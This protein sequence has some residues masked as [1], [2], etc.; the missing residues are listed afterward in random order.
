MVNADY[1]RLIQVLT[2]LLSNAAKFSPPN[3]EVEISVLRHEKNIRISVT[4]HGPGIPKEFHDRIFERFAQ[5]DPM[6]PRH[7]QGAGLGLSIVKAIVERLGGMIDFE[8]NPD[9]GTTFY[10]ELPEY[11]KDEMPSAPGA[12]TKKKPTI[13]ICEDDPDVATLLSLILKQGGY[14]TEIAYDATQAKQLL[15][16]NNYSAMTLDIKLPDQDGIS[17]IKELA[18]REN[19]RHLPIVVVSANTQQW[20]SQLDDSKY[21][22]I[23]WLDKPIDQTHLMSVMQKICFGKG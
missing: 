15:N 8:T 5:A 2:N 1:D 10:F 20:R 4:D 14:H 17:L 16:K 6:D 13:L 23:D 11:H 18:E 7:K 9:L 22:V 21:S 12:K 3:G 19:T